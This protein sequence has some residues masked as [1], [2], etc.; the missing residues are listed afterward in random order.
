M[1]NI[2]ESFDSAGHYLGSYEIPLLE[3]TRAQLSSSMDNIS[4][5]PFAE[6]VAFFESK[7]HDTLLYDVQIDYWRNR[8]S[9]KVPYKTLPGDIVI[10]TSAR[11]GNVSDLQRVGWAWTLAVVT[12]IRGDGDGDAAACTSFKVK[13]QNDIEIG[14]GGQKSLTVI[15]LTSLTTSKRIWKALH[16]F[17]NLNIIKKILCIDS[18]VRVK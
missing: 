11:P 17:R 14:E 2:P 16:M 3:E 4:T 1:E 7:P 13:V 8:S 6:V 5:A 9:G 18:A 10:L 15:S 12:N